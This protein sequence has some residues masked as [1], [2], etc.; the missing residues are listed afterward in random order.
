M[1]EWTKGQIKHGLMD[2]GVHKN[3]L[4]ECMLDLVKGD[5]LF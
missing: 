5:L 1:D 4:L 3:L 2:G